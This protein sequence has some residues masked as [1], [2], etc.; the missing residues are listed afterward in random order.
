[1]YFHSSLEYIYLQVML[2]LHTHSTRTRYINSLTYVFWLKRGRYGMNMNHM[3]ALKSLESS[4]LR[5]IFY[6]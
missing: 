6:F 3:I 2:N 1:M 5:Q 4:F